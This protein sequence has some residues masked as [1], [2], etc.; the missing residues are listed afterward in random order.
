M[1][2]RLL[3]MCVLIAVTMADP[4]GK[5]KY[6]AKHVH[7]NP[8]NNVLE[9]IQRALVWPNTYYD[10]PRHR[11]P[12]YNHDGTGKLLYGYGGPSLYHYTVF[13]PLEGYFRR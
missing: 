12:Y 1:K 6:T 7:Q 11:H 13:R 3:L 8:N 2:T 5:S 9:K 10:R 4:L